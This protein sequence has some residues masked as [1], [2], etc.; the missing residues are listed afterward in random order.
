M[1]SLDFL[2]FENQLAPQDPNSSQTSSTLCQNCLEIFQQWKSS[3]HAPS[4]SNYFRHPHLTTVDLIRS[5]KSCHMCFLLLEPDYKIEDDENL[6]SRINRIRIYNLSTGAYSMTLREMSAGQAG[7]SAFSRT[8][9]GQTISRT[10]IKYSC[11]LIY[12]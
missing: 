5:A 4:A 12:T 2:A 10:R 1:S 6:D 7:D 11:L 3:G 8:L 9:Y